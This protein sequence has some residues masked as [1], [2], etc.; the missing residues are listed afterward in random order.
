MNKTNIWLLSGPPGSGK[1]YFAKNILKTDDT[2]A[3]ISRDE[4]R[5]AM[6]SE[7]E[8]YFSKE[9]QVFKEFY[10]RILAACQSSNIYNII[11]DATHLNVNSRMKILNKLPIKDLNIFCVYFDTSKEVC[12]QRNAMRSGRACVPTKVLC[13]MYDSRTYPDQ[14]PIKYTG[15]LSISGE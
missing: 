3:Y 1:S 10:N 12:L 9:K 6:V 15:I 2:W 14:D 7:D 8:D 5:F 11:I 13:D 4:I